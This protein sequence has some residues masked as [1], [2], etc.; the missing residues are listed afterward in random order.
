MKPTAII[1]G[2]KSVFR[3]KQKNFFGI[4]A[5]C[6][7][8]S[9][10]AGISIT[11]QSLS[12]GFGMF[13]TY[14][15][16]EVDGSV[17]YA[18]GFF[19]GS[20][21]QDIGSN[22][23]TLKNVTAYTSE[24]SLPVTTS[25]AGGQISTSSVLKGIVDD[26][27]NFGEL[28]VSSSSS[29]K[30]S[31]LKANE[32]YIGKVLADDLR[33][34]AG[35]NFNYSFTYGPMHI[36]QE[37][38]VKNI[39]INEQRGAMANNEGIFL[40]LADLQKPYNFQFQQ[41]GV[42]IINPVTVIYLRFSNVVSSDSDAENLVT[43]MKNTVSTNVPVLK[44]LGGVN[45]FH[46]TTDRIS[47]K[48]YGKGLADALGSLLT[49]F[50]SILILAGLILIVNIQLMTIENKE[51][52]IGIQ[53]A[54]G[55]KNYQ[56]ILS[57]L[58]E[59]I[60]TGIF[61]GLVGILGGAIFGWILINAFG[62]AFGFDGSLIPLTIPSSIPVT[63][64][65]VGFG[66]SILAGLYPAIKA[67]R[68]N[69]IEV[70]RGI[71]TKTY[72]S[73]S[74]SGIWGFVLGLLLTVLGLFS[75]MSL[76]KN[77]LDYP[78][79]YRNVSDAE[80]IYV[81]TTLLMVGILVLLSY[82][83][84]RNMILT[85][86][87]LALLLYPTIQL[88]FVFTQIREGSGGTTAIV[89]MT[90]SLICGAV[91]IVGLNLDKIANLSD[92]IFSPFF[93][94]V[95]LISFKQMSS[96]KTRSTLTFTIFA[97]I[98]TLNIFLATWSY[99]ARYGQEQ[100]VNILSGE[101]D[102]L[103]ISNLPLSSDIASSYMSGLETKFSS[104]ITYATAFPDS[105]T[106][107]LFLNNNGTINTDKNA[108]NTFALDLFSVSPT[109]LSNGND[110]MINFMLMPSKLNNTQF[111]FP[112]NYSQG[113]E[114]DNKFETLD[115]LSD[116]NIQENINA[117]NFFSS[118]M[119]VINKTSGAEIPVIITSSIA[120]LDLATQS[121]KTLKQVSDPVWLKLNNGTFQ[122]FLII[123]TSPD[124]PIF[125]STILRQVTGAPTL[126]SGAFVQEK[127]ARQLAAFNP[128]P[129]FSKVNQANYFV[130]TSTYSVESNQNKIL[131]QNIESWSNG[132]TSGT[133][134]SQENKLYGF[135]SIPVY[136][137]YETSFDGQFRV[138][139]FM[140]YFTTLGFLFGVVSLLVVSVRSVQERKREIGMM[141]SIGIKR[142]D[143]VIA[144]ILE[145][146]VMGTIGLL[147]GIFNGNILAYGLVA[148]NG[149][150]YMNFLI[151]WDTIFIY[152][153]LTL[154][155]A[156]FASII[157]GRIAS[158]IPP[159]DALRYTG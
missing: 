97:F 103:I 20:T 8:V 15:L 5:I 152:T 64:F 126:V 9:L 91:L 2:L 60:I 122:E 107:E 140:Q 79:A 30:V 96:Q 111:L 100:Q 78:V 17:T 104:S 105:G 124:N 23:M 6:L 32:V 131:A 24:L 127:W 56:I 66:I 109:T 67:S 121:T 49:I 61:G 113:L 94:A 31:D 114:T 117:W 80:S 158:M 12:T 18:N 50:G 10:I 75:V 141:R 62:Y 22:L 86:T 29:V 150:G 19:N 45:S 157:P 39:V 148:V 82:F 59:F 1:F 110:Q 106:T 90:V 93:S 88:L 43:Q 53:R 51:K 14:S 137:I 70:L 98:L 151:P 52:Q 144:L 99:S 112:S 69:V 155:S 58:T 125:D 136:S 13:F 37:F 115:Y 128:N 35:D 95:S 33:I 154:G 138:F 129:Q 134:R 132:D 68:I 48:S 153:I 77:P 27:T 38:L 142:R 71:E 101:S 63:A 57:N 87:G 89:V 25:T 92:K 26:P 156:L 28:L 54:V 65:V 143:V 16:G 149:A 159:S 4:F 83:V 146:S 76:S 46:F 42:N 44:T 102:I 133:F 120:S 118:G 11:D 73:N 130:V 36:D 55:T 21:A 47:I 34:K 3:R 41:F 139:Q 116:S 72:K 81:S 147:I 108:V 123:A 85:I 74:G 7:G 135:M 119:G 145:L 84:S 40:K